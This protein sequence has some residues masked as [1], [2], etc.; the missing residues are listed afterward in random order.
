VAKIFLVIG[1]GTF[2]ART[3]RALY[4]KGAEVLAID[5]LEEEV[6]RIRDD[7]TQAIC[8]DATNDEAL[9]RVGAF[10][11]DAAV[12]A[13][14]RRFDITVLVTHSLKRHGMKEICVRVDSE[15]E[16]EAIK[17][18][19]AT[20]II[21]PERDMAERLAT[22]LMISD[23]AEQIPLGDNVGIIEV[24]CP[25]SMV[26]K[27][28]IELNFRKTIGVTVIALKSLNE[29]TLAPHIEVA[30]APDKALR[31]DQYLLLLGDTRLLGKFKET[32]AAL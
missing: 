18:V 11:T 24:A 12:I 21:F 25:K 19:G 23:L 9:E 29:K 2:G 20:D 8:A 31:A 22:R 6:D 14:R 28:L 17:T 10:T 7:V 16:A 26:G 5:I 4:R 3:A 32:V 30:P 15:Q 1:L 27:T 13:V